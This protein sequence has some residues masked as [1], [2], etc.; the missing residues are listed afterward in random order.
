MSKPLIHAQ[1][2]ARKFGGLPSDYLDI[3]SLL[4]SS[5]SITSLP[6]HRAITHNTFFISTILTRIF[7]ET[8]KRSSDG[9]EVST[10][11]IGEQHVAED[12]HGFIPSAADFIDNLD[13]AEWMM[14]GKGTPPSYARI[15]KQRERKIVP[16]KAPLTMHLVD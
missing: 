9:K 3:H 7:G 15:V 11:D 2:S 1:S 14:N 12:Y 8:F 6:T 10:R 16:N 5:K 13:V 4:D